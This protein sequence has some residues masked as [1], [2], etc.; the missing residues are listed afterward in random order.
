MG[1][2]YLERGDCDLAYFVYEEALLLQTTIFPK[3]HELV[4]ESLVSLALTRA[5]ENQPQKALQILQGCLR[6]QNVRYGKDSI[7]TID[8]LGYLGYLYEHLDCQEDALK[9]LAAVKKWQ[10]LN[11]PP[12]HPALRKTR[13]SVKRL[14]DAI[15]KKVSVW[16]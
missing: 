10:K 7:E 3:D 15:G 14:E 13:E 8:T 4:L 11:L 6:S 9:C 12:G 5:R 1:K 2:L 16:I